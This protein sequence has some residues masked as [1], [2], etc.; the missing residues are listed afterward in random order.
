MNISWQTRR[1]GSRELF[2]SALPHLETELMAWK[3]AAAA[4]A[5]LEPPDSLPCFTSPPSLG[6]KS[7]SEAPLPPGGLRSP[8]EPRVLGDAPDP[9]PGSL[10]VCVFPPPWESAPPPW[11]WGGGTR[12]WPWG[13]GSRAAAS[14]GPNA[15]LGGGRR[16]RTASPGVPV[17]GRGQGERGS[18]GSTPTGGP[19]AGAVLQCGTL[20]RQPRG[21]GTAG[22][23]ERAAQP[24]G[25]RREHLPAGVPVPGWGGGGGC[26]VPVPLAQSRSRSLPP[27]PRTH[28]VSAGAGTG[29]REGPGRRSAPVPPVPPV[30][31]RAGGGTGSSARPCPGSRSCAGPSARQGHR[32]DRPRSRLP[33]HPR[34]CR[35]PRPGLRAGNPR[36]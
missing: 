15:Q 32:P 26:P 1:A 8:P 6:K 33:P 10:G 18:L 3:W 29:P 5:P 36:D 34:Y 13:R 12:A 11:G 22:T 17:P 21:C 7:V 27:P 20:R 25:R 35:Y 4:G 16:S 14:G 28:R 24:G 2:M 9:S 23:R 31:F 30:R 19:G